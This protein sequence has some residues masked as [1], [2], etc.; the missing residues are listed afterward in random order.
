M[1]WFEIVKSRRNYGVSFWAKTGENRRL[2][3]WV[4]F[5]LNETLFA[6]F[7]DRLF[8]ANQKRPDLIREIKKSLHINYCWTLKKSRLDI[9]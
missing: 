8:R 9:A 6:V 7:F 3:F 4:F 2:G 1:G 5:G